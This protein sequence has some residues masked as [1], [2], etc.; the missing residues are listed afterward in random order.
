MNC[1]ISVAQFNVRVKSAAVAN[2]PSRHAERV[3]VARAQNVPDEDHAQHYAD[4]RD[5]HATRSAHRT[6][7]AHTLATI[8]VFL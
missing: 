7:A 5:T 3:C 8:V 4:T 1:A 6:P 2:K